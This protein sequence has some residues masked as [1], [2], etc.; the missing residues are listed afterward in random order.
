MAYKKF[1]EWLKQLK[2]PLKKKNLNIFRLILKYKK[3][4]SINIM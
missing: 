4:V 1:N 3:K 2:K